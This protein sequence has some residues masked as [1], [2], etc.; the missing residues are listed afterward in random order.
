MLGDLQTLFPL[1]RNACAQMRTPAHTHALACPPARPPA[2]IQCV[3]N[4]PTGCPSGLRQLVANSFLRTHSRGMTFAPYYPTADR[5]PTMSVHTHV[6][7]RPPA[8]AHARDCE[9]MCAGAHRPD[10][11]PTICDRA[12]TTGQA[13]E[14]QAWVRPWVRAAC[15]CVCVR[16]CVVACVACAQGCICA[17]RAHSSRR[18]KRR[19]ARFD[20][21]GHV[22]ACARGCVPMACEKE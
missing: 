17:G 12:A 19:P 11:L 20:E 5:P 6:R 13:Q 10:K 15:V 18:R 4:H 7:A 14:A 8:C 2:R 16:A 21:C 1:H 9:H 22:C 3:A